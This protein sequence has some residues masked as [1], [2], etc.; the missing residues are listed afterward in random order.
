MIYS[1]QDRCWLVWTP[2]PVFTPAPGPPTMVPGWT[3]DTPTTIPGSCGS[4]D[5]NIHC[6]HC[7]YS[8]AKPGAL[9]PEQLGPWAL[10][11]RAGAGLGR[12]DRWLWPP[13]S[14]PR[15]VSIKSSWRLLPPPTAKQSSRRSPGS[16][17]LHIIWLCRR[18]QPLWAW[19]QLP[20]LPR[21]QWQ[22]PG[23]HRGP[24]GGGGEPRARG[25]SWLCRQWLPPPPPGPRTRILRARAEEEDG[26][27]WLR[28]GRG[29]A[30]GQ[31]HWELRGRGA[32]GGIRLDDHSG[33]EDRAPG[34][35]QVARGAGGADDAPWSGP[36]RPSPLGQAGVPGQPG[37]VRMG[38]AEE[39]PSFPSKWI[40]RDDLS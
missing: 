13:R 1:L 3:Q 11:A 2:R 38:R 30:G 14:Q 10:A 29:Q 20:Q 23:D 33:S 8:Q 6:K 31:R 40:F 34:G 7:L 32:G 27:V 17:V 35:H 21:D 4:G 22:P 26:E 37:Q 15:P 18:H 28:V 39:V 36:P 9:G 19:V 24:P 16:P 12:A 5:H 25:G